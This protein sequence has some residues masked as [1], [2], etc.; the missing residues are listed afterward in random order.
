[1]IEN[2]FRTQNKFELLVLV[3]LRETKWY[4]YILLGLLFLITSPAISLI[5]FVLFFLVTVDEEMN[6]P[7]YHECTS[8]E[9]DQAKLEPFI[10]AIVE[11]EKSG[12]LSKD[13]KIK[14][15]NILSMLRSYF[16]LYPMLESFSPDELINIDED[17]LN[18]LYKLAFSSWEVATLKDR[19][20]LEIYSVFQGNIATKKSKRPNATIHAIGGEL[21]QKSKT[22]CNRK[23]T[24]RTM[25][26]FNTL[27]G[28]ITCKSC[29]RK[30]EG[31]EY[32][33]K[34]SPLDSLGKTN[35]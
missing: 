16:C 22:L 9:V 28:E 13:K 24:D 11:A 3:F 25:A 35:D 23:L 2:K 26:W 19:N 14:L 27:Q 31:L 33:Y 32:T 1:M 30:M 20:G 7:F 34:D 29:L 6:K 5:I 21:S 10:E 17:T 18:I 12:T 8:H 4:E 15:G